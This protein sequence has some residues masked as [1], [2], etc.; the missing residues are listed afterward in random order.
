MASSV[1]V[2]MPSIN[3]DDLNAIHTALKYGMFRAGIKIRD[4][5]YDLAPKDTWALASSG[6]VTFE[7]D[8][9]IKITFGQY[10]PDDRAVFQEFGTV[11]HPPHSYLA[12]AVAAIDI[13]QEV[14]TSLDD[15]L[16]GILK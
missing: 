14:K 15:V 16:S 10:L 9:E 12:P 5:A 6:N 13:V 8:T 1:T 11:H 4:L 3:A 7:S 2:T